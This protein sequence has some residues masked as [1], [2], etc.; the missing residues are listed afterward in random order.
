MARND[1]ADWDDFDPEFDEDPDEDEDDESEPTVECPYCSRSIHEDAQ[2]CPYCEQYISEDDR[3]P[4]R[5]P[6]WIVLGVIVCL[7]VVYRWIVP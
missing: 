3:P 1:D 5:R 7:Y 6:W 2:R 4:E